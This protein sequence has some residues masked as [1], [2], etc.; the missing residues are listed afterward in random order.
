MKPAQIILSFARQREEAYKAYGLFEDEKAKAISNIKKVSSFFLK[1]D[2]TGWIKQ[3]EGDIYKVLPS[4]ESPQKMAREKI[5][6]LMG[7]NFGPN[8]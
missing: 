1:T 8:T 6:S 5:L 3:I 4:E 7:K 2:K